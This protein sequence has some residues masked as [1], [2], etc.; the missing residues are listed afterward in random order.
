MFC[1]HCGKEVSEG[2]TFC[3]HCGSRL[4]EALPAAPDSGTREKTP[5][6]NREQRG[7]FGGL[8]ETLKQVLFSPGDF[9]KKMPVTGGLTDPLLYGLILGMAGAL[10][11]YFW[12]I[13]LHGVMQNYMTREMLAA[14]EYSLFQGASLALLAIST[15]FFIILWL[16]LIAGMFHVFLLMVQGAKSGFEATFRVVAYSVS[17]FLFLALPICGGF[18]AWIWSLISILIGFQ[19]AH[20]TTGGKAAFAVFLPLLIC[21]GF[22]ITMAAVFMGAMVASFGSMMNP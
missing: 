10:F 8:F 4:S 12:Q 2:Q 3:Q 16:F 19:H 9:F 22:V 5:W 11:S 14:S 21:C 17:P 1:P 20:E 13:A 18:L 15:P 7:F 6:E